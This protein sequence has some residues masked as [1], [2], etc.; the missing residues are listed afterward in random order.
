M[1]TYGVD[2]FVTAVDH[3]WP[4]WARIEVRQAGTLV[5]TVYTSPWNGY[6]EIAA[7][8]N[9][10]T[11]DFTVHS[12]YM[13][14][15]DEVRP[16]TLASGDQ[17]QS[18]SLLAADGNPAYSCTFAQGT[19]LNE[20]FN[21]A[22][23]PLGWTVVD[24]VNPGNSWKRNDA[25]G[26]SNLVPGGSGFSA[27]ADSDSAG[28]GSGNFDTELRTPTF[29][30]PATPRNLKFKHNFNLLASTDRAYVDVTTNGGTSW[31]NLRTFTA[32]STTEQTID[33]SA[34]A[35]QSVMFRF[36]YVSGD[37]M[38]YWQ[39]DDVR[40]STP[41][42][43]DDVPVLVC[44]PTTGSM[45]AGFVTDANTTAGLA[46]AQV[47]RDLGGVAP[48][49]A[50]TGNL[51]A[52][53]YYMFSAVP[54]PVAP[55]GPSTRTFTASKTGYG[56]LA[57]SVNLIPNTTNRLDF[58]LAAASLSLAAWPFV[59]DGR[60]TPDGLPAWDKTQTFSILNSGGLRRQREGESLGAGERLRSADADAA[61][62]PA[63][64]GPGVRGTE[65][66]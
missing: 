45:V 1:G 35:S 24:N 57:Q 48:T 4:L 3:D 60:L 17:V 42:G 41:A 26:A 66:P 36:R 47:V 29:T 38:W 19:G 23:P 18:F 61:A 8:P 25:W 43:V 34:Y 51:P 15:Q 37:W 9:G 59:V 32:D 33:V 44:E 46:G 5:S 20:N 62:R 63:R 28:S 6:Y 40:T 56:S 21:G 55:N 50:A 58:S 64:H 54:A 30:M 14:Y 65:P 22:F 52:G 7:L 11:Y 49:M 12:M 31:T 16:V 2:G 39:V 27:D 13:G 53:F 10:F